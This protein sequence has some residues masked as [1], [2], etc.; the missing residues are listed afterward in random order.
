MNDSYKAIF[1]QGNHKTQILKSIIKNNRIS[2]AYIFN[3]PEG[4]GRQAAAIDFIAEIINK[5]NSDNKAL[6]KIKAKTFPDLILIE[7]TYLINGKLIKQSELEEDLNQRNNPIIRIDQIREIRKFLGI[8]SIQSDKKFVIVKDAHFMNEAASNCLLKTLEEPD[9]GL[10]ILITSHINKL[11]ET[12]KSRCQQIQ[13]NGLS[14]NELYN[15]LKSKKNFTEDIE[16]RISHLQDLIYLANGSPKNLWDNISIW[17]EIPEA[18][19]QKILTPIYEYIEILILVKRI[20]D[21]LDIKQ[22]NFLVEFIQYRWWNE[23]R[24]IQI[25][26]TIENLKMNLKNNIQPRLAWE[27]SL[28]KIALNDS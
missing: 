8:R 11:L 9:N 6:E 24:N 14:N 7:P 21:E 20:T 26:K 22:Q 17:L 18:I 4:V 3:G 12:V 13:F 5:S 25:I 19:K 16:S 1:P 2:N 15:Q 28:L 10:F 23:T 27:A